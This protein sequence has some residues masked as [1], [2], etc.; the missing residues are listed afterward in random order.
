MELR[1]QGI[2]PASLATAA[3]EATPTPQ[4]NRTNRAKEASGPG[5][6]GARRAAAVPVSVRSAC[7]ASSTLPGF[8]FG[9]TSDFMGNRAEAHTAPG[10]R[11]PVRSGR[12]T[13]ASV[14]C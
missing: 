6:P 10:G 13:Q 1:A 7:H 5:V 4:P 3:L 2:S 8:S 14:G 9:E 11:W 12:A